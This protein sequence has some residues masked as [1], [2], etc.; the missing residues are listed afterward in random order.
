MGNSIILRTRQFLDRMF[1]AVSGDPRYYS[2]EHRLFNTISLLNAVTNLGGALFILNKHNYPFLL[3][4]QVGTGVLFLIFYYFS[5]FRNLYR[6]LYWP[7]VLLIGIF[8]FA[9]SLRNAG[10]M[11]GA[12][13]YFIPA[14]VIAIVLSRR[15]FTTILAIALFA[16]TTSALLLLEHLYP[17]WIIAYS[18]PR[19]RLFD[20]LLSFVFVQIFTGIVVMVLAKN[21]NQ[22]RQK[23]DRLLLNILPESIAQELQKKDRVQPLEYDN[24][25]VLFTDFVG[26]TRIAEGLTPQELIEELDHCFRHFDEIA[27]RHNLEKIKT[28]GDA[29]MAVGGI[30][31]ANHTHAV[32]CVL[33]ALEIERFM[34]Q[35]REEKMTKQKPYWQLRLGIHS[36]RL[37]AGVI[38]QEKF[39]Y[40]V[41]GDTVNTAS[42]LESSGVAGRINIS[43][44][45]YERVQGFFVCEYRGAI[46]AKNKGD[47]EMYFVNGIRPELAR[48][49]A[50]HLPNEKFLELYGKLNPSPTLTNSAPPLI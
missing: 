25:S 43:R 50:G 44:A 49:A 33:G 29:Y 9:N 38:G 45:T 7:F 14:L 19:E 11:G 13:Y 32:D 10:S 31:E 46:A 6:P 5:R 22:E 27:K 39:S 35:M 15:A 21:L 1:S 42:R 30:P 2:L 40:D 47:I 24:A 20:T 26:F 37:V 3:L 48:D 34:T 16:V 36:G 28:I 17:E 23:S 8:L 4:L 18:T 41:W 12:H